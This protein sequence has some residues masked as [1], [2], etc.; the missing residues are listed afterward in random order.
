M[1]LSRHAILYLFLEL[2]YFDERARL[3]DE[4]EEYGGLNLDQLHQDVYIVWVYL[5]CLNT[6][7]NHIN[8]A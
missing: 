2:N 7:I 5:R 3:H 4:E 6:Y 8:F 1:Q